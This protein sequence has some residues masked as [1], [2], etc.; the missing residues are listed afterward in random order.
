MPAAFADVFKV[1]RQIG[2]RYIWIDSLCI[3]QD[4]PN[5]VDSEIIQMP[6]IYKNAALTICASVSRSSR[7]GFLHPR[8]D[9]S[10]MKIPLDLPR[11]GAGT[12]YLD[13][14]LWW[15][16]PAPEP[17]SERAWAFQE[18]LLSPRLLEYGWRTARWTCSCTNGYSGGTILSTNEIVDAASEPNMQP[19][20]YNLFMYLNPPGIRNL[21]TSRT[22][23][24]ECWAAIVYKYSALKLTFPED[25]LAAIGGV[26]AELQHITGVRYLA[27]LWHHERLPSLLQWK[28]V[29][30]LGNLCQRPGTIRTPSWSWAG[31][32]NEV[33]IHQSKV[34]IDAFEV[35]SADAMG[36]FGKTAHGFIK[37]K[38]PLS[39]G[40]RWRGTETVQVEL[41][42]AG[43]VIQDGLGPALTIWPDCA[44]EFVGFVDGYPVVSTM[45]LELDLL[46][47]GRTN[48]D[49]GI[50]RGLVLTRKE[51]SEELYTRVAM[52]QVRD[53][54]DFSI[55]NWGIET[56]TIV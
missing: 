10:E 41:S 29:S 54:G 22:D 56:I 9:Y 14:F 17:L 15:S 7:E 50:V 40:M 27:G 26:A 30:S 6:N 45:R 32:D 28:V 52:F 47:I 13:S 12:A 11:G 16:P 55:R 4:D 21:P 34:A 46:A 5:D 35:I 2:F 1:T 37:L 8:E 18:R 39:R 23:F 42:Q 48:D 19:R 51:A 33:I 3:I 20:P 53:E 36:G 43:L 24:F 25:R 49:H 38:G 44:E 31:L